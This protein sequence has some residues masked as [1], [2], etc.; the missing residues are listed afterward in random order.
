MPELQARY[1][2]VLTSIGMAFSESSGRL[3]LAHLCREEVSTPWVSIGLAA[4]PLLPGA[5]TLLVEGDAMTKPVY[6]LGSVLDIVLWSTLVLATFSC[7]AFGASASVQVAQVLGVKV[8][9][10]EKERADGTKAEY[11]DEYGDEYEDEDNDDRE[12]GRSGSESEGED[13][14]QE[15]EEYEEEERHGS[16]SR[17]RSN[18]RPI[19][20]TPKK[21]NKPK[22]R[23]PNSV[24]SAGSRKFGMDTG[25]EDG[26]RV[27]STEGKGMTLLGEQTTSASSMSP[28]SSNAQVSSRKSSGR[29]KSKSK[30]PATSSSSRQSIGKKTPKAETNSGKKSSKRAASR[31]RDRGR[32]PV[33]S[34]SSKAKKAGSSS[35]GRTFG[36]SDSSGK[37]GNSGGGFIRSASKTPVTGSNSKGK[38]SAKR[39]ASRPRGQRR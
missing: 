26:E 27:S 14:E 16:G 37:S 17:R 22:T 39:T 32:T 1:I 34:K 23:T 13:D 7:M 33:A 8:L 12:N 3:M 11:D 21:K 18:S 2:V 25:H 31:G 24:S 9:T 38:G 6:G 29:G 35:T 5:L 4:A 20:K 15:E 28:V 10:I 36:M 19:H 30:S